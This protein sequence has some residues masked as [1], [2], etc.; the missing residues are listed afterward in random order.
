V[1]PHPSIPRGSDSGAHGA[2]RQPQTLR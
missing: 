2:H 1:H